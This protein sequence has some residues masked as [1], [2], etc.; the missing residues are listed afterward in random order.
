MAC[1]ITFVRVVLLNS[2]EN[3]GALDPIG[4]VTNMYKITDDLSK[5]F[6]YLNIGRGNACA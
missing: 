4:S 2:R 6:S 1:C 5:I 3:D